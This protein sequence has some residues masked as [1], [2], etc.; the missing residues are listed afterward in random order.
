METSKVQSDNFNISLT[1]RPL[2]IYFLQIRYGQ[3]IVGIYYEQGIVVQ[4]DIDIA[5]Q[6]L[7][8]AAQQGFADA[9]AALGILLV[10]HKN[11]ITQG[12]RWL[13]H[14]AQ[15]VHNRRVTVVA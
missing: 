8:S 1:Y 6:Y 5:E 2:H 10:D 15:V 12:K 4:R 9:Q 7:L 14:A 13:E 3:Y 11:D